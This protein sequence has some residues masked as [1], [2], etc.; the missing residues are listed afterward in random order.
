MVSSYSIVQFVMNVL[1]LYCSSWRPRSLYLSLFKLFSLFDN[2]LFRFFTR[3]WQ[4]VSVSSTACMGLSNIAARCGGATT[5][6]M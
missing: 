4:L 2:L 6:H 3:T 5:L 1:G